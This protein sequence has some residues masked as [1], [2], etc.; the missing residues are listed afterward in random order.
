ML[1]HI[2][3]HPHQWTITS[4]FRVQYFAFVDAVIQH[5]VKRFD[6]PGMKTYRDMKSVLLSACRAETLGGGVK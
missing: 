4:E 5:I 3:P 2:H 1:Q 6:Q